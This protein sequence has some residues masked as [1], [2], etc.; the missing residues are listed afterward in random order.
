MKFLGK[1]LSYY[2]M[3]SETGWIEAFR[4]FF[5]IEVQKVPIVKF[6]RKGVKIHMHRD[7]TTVWAIQNSIKKIERLVNEIPLDD[8]TVVLDVGAN[9]GLFTL[10][11][12][13]RFPRAK[14]YAFEPS[15]V[16]CEVIRKN[17]S[18]FD[19]VEVIGHA[20]TDADGAVVP[21]FIDLESQENNSLH[22]SVLSGK[23]LVTQIAVPTLR[24]D[25]FV[26]E[27]KIQRI[28]VLK[29]DIQG[30]EGALLRGGLLV[31]KRPRSQSSKYGFWLLMCL[32]SWIP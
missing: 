1:L 3:T 6:Y 24:L 32:K 26:E 20:I 15:P 29:V 17:T 22:A 12:K 8:P 27:R 21:L 16:L 30:S 9:C 13:T 10:F 31:Y 18:H 23:K 25:T 4:L 11:V 2:Y 28:D 14:V 5:Q 19:G 7:S